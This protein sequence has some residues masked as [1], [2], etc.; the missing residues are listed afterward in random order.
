MKTI[1]NEIDVTLLT[2]GL[3]DLDSDLSVVTPAITWYREN[4]S[5]SHHIRIMIRSKS[6]NKL[7]LTFYIHST[8]EGLTITRENDTPKDKVNEIAMLIHKF[9]TYNPC[10]CWS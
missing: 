7:I 4:E 10:L 5:V 2:E 9:I 6:T 1:I 3:K 8:G